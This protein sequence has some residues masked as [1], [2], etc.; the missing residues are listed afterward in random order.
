MLISGLHFVRSIQLFSRMSQHLGVKSS[1][2]AWTTLSTLC[3][4]RGLVHARAVQAD[5]LMT[6]SFL[7]RLRWMLTRKRDC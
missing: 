5:S 2:R 4:V 1:G 3:L 7:R 6:P